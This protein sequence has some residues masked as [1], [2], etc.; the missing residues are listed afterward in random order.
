MFASASK[1]IWNECYVVVAIAVVVVIVEGFTFTTD[2]KK[3]SKTNSDFQLYSC[4]HQLNSQHC[5]STSEK[6]VLRFLVGIELDEMRFKLCRLRVCS[7]HPNSSVVRLLNSPQLEP[8][9]Y[10]MPSQ[11]RLMLRSEMWRVCGPVTR[12]R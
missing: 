11:M 3:K 4:S 7:L 10:A 9:R 8:T 1:G 2:E 5:S 6:S 12:L